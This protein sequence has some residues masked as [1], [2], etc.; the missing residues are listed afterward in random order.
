[1]IHVEPEQ[2]FYIEYQEATQRRSFPKVNFKVDYLGELI[3]V[4]DFHV[5]GNK[6]PTFILNGRLTGVSNL[7]LT[8]NRVLQAGVNASNALIQNRSYV[9]TP[10]DGHLT[11]GVVNLEAGSKMLFSKHLVLAT[12]LF[13]MRK[14]AILSADSMVISVKEAHIEGGAAVITSGRG[15]N[16]GTVLGVG[17]SAS[18]VGSGAGHGGLGGPS[19][20]SPGG[21][22]YGSFIYP[23]HPGSVG[24]AGSSGVGGGA[25]GSTIKVPRIYNELFTGLFL[26]KVLFQ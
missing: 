3:V 26:F 22:G 2:T 9:T 16:P 19:T 25:A 24:G 17:T 11:F 4:S 21:A 15:P 6:N 13:S 8:D 20:T 10:I 12:D 1:M 14:G 18:G 23:S 7:T 5:S